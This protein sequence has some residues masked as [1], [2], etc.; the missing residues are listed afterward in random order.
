MLEPI[1]RSQG[2]GA[3]IVHWQLQAQLCLAGLLRRRWC[4]SGRGA[5]AVANEKRP[6]LTHCN[7]VQHKPRGG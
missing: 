5:V 2:H 4:C 6:M 7:P 3:V 1:E